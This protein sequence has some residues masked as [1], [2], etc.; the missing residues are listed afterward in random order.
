MHFTKP[1][2]ENKKMKF[3]MPTLL[4]YPSLSDCAA[5]AERFGLDFVEVN[6]SFPGYTAEDLDIDLLNDLA[7]KHGIFYTFH[8][9]EGLNP[10]DFT[11][12]VSE[13]YFNIMRK[14]IRLAKGVRIPLS[15]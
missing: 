7:K 5:A 6:L 9:D 8:A 15:F 10:F 14:T 4:E 1:T 2:M 11:P 3:G 12:S 13:C